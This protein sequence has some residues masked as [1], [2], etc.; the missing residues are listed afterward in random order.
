MTNKVEEFNITIEIS[1]IYANTYNACISRENSTG[2][3]LNDVTAEE[4]G[5][6]L[7]DEINSLR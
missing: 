2:I 7:I 5:E 6:R 3:K 1:S 4:I